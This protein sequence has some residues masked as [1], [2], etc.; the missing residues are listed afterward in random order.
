MCNKLINSQ[1]IK[2]QRLRSLNKIVLIEVTKPKQ[3]RIN[4]GYE[5]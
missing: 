4:R 1:A 3:N 2:K 5:A